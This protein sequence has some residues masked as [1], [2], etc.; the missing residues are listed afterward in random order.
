[1][2]RRRIFGALALG[3]ALSLPALAAD[4]NRAPAAGRTTPAAAPSEIRMSKLIGM[5]VHG[6]SGERLGDVKDVVLDAN[7]GRVHYAVLSFGGFLGLGDKLFAVP[8]SKLRPGGSGRLV[9]DVDKAQLASAPGFDLKKWPDWMSD[10]YRAEVDRRYGVPSPAANARFRRASRVLDA[11][12]RDANG[13]DIGDIEDMV[14]DLRNG[15]VH[16]VVVEFDRAWNPNDKLIA[17]PMTALGAM[18]PAAGQRSADASS[19]PRNPPGVLSLESPS[20][21][22]QGK[23]SATSPPGGVPTRPAPIAP[24]PESAP[25]PLP[26]DPAG[27]RS[28]ADDEDLMY[29]GT[30]EQLRNAPEFDKDRYPD[31]RDAASRQAFDRRLST[32]R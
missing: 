9:V 16:Y 25:V 1:M 3:F 19:P 27:Q 12:V 20:G 24:S 14:V 22:T 7:T 18:T 5:N 13:A 2:T 10:P 29:A 31:L 17:L 30:R 26:R 23:A 8:L 28:Y 15:N 32:T 6:A 4:T 11:E 21:P